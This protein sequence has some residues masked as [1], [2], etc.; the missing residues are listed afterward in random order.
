M[1]SERSISPLAIQRQFDRRVAA[2]AQ[3]DFLFREAEA[4]M[5]ERLE[6]IRAEPARMLDLGC[7][8]GRSFAALA[9]RYP[10]ARLAGADLSH[11]AL[12]VA[13]AAWRGP[14]SSWWR[15]LIGARSI[16]PDLVQASFTA[17]PF[18]DASFDMLFS[19]LALHYVSDPAV[20]FAEWAR[21]A[22]EQGLLMFSC[23]GPD[24]LKEVRAAWAGV[25]QE[26]VV[27]PFVDMHDLGD[28]LLESGF[29]A[30]V[31][32]MEFLTLTY[33]SVDAMLA[34][35]RAVTGNPLP[36]RTR[37]LSGRQRFERARRAVESMRGP[38]GL[39][40]VTIELVNGH[41]WRA[42]PRQRF[43]RGPDGAHVA[44]VPLER[45]GRSRPGRN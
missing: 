19:N 3:H 45:V 10:K 39:L 27:I 11:A 44:R 36:A 31:V 4:R 43:E 18:C 21:V 16:G 9:K 35:L 41:A 42:T 7:G 6:L 23:F 15:S 25:A 13:H 24:T 8:Q 20:A 32:D 12:S 5:I 38:D 17:L 33:T 40:R 29:A 2:F 14:N 34:D 30:P 28:M 26:P 22:T 1:T 37:G